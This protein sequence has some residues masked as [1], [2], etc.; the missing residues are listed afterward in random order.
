LSGVS[1][2]DILK[3]EIEALHKDE[4]VGMVHLQKIW[5]KLNYCY[6]I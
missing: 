2:F 5:K 4:A 3:K 1:I 6:P